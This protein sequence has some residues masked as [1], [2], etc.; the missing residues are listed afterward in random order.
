MYMCMRMHMHMHMC[1]CMYVAQTLRM[2]KEL[3]CF[4]VKI[5]SH[6]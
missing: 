6:D 5:V 3:D 2:G 4:L 1:M